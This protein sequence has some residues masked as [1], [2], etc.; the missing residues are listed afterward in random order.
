LA[1]LTNTIRGAGAR[2][3][4]RA[5]IY[6]SLL[7]LVS[8]GLVACGSG[9][10]VE[11]TVPADTSPEQETA[12]SEAMHR[13]NAMAIEE[14]GETVLVWGGYATDPVVSFSPRSA[15]NPIKL[16]EA[17]SGRLWVDWENL[18]DDCRVPAITHE[19]GHLLGYLDRSDTENEPD[20]GIMQHWTL[21]TEEGFSETDRMQMRI[22]AQTQQS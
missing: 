7:S 8:L 16:G 1:E 9:W 14:V 4:I 17:M 18:P 10:P 2:I 20:R 12:T 6:R 3:G 22:L 11:I 15:P 19:M 13:W 5:V 21:W